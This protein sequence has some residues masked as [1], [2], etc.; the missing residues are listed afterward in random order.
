MSTNSLSLLLS[1]L[2]NWDSQ[3]SRAFVGEPVPLG[4]PLS[5][6]HYKN[7]IENHREAGME[8]LRSSLPLKESPEVTFPGMK[9]IIPVAHNYFLDHDN[10]NESLPSPS[11]NSEDSHRSSHLE[12]KTT[13]QPAKSNLSPE[14][15]PLNSLRT[16]HYS[17]G[18]DYHLWFREK[19]RTLEAEIQK[20]FPDEQFLSFT[21]SVPILERDFARQAGLGWRGKN[22]CLI[23]PKRGSFF[24][25]GEI[26]TSIEV[27]QP[28]SLMRNFCGTCNACVEAC[29][30]QALGDW[31]LDGNRCISYWNIEAKGV[32]P[33]K[34]RSSLGDWF[35][36]CDICQTVCPWNIKWHGKKEGFQANSENVT[37]EEI[38]NSENTQSLQG[39]VNELRWVLTSSNREL[40]K[41][42][43]ATALMRAGG[44]GLK[45]NA[46]I[47]AAN[48]KLTPL[49]PEIEAFRD[50]PRLGELAHWAINS[51]NS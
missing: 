19:L 33:E 39:L 49:L 43:G 1:I 2:K 20:Q 31:G 32:A 34:L 10:R 51:L 12:H 25:I 24:F 40:Q 28:Q 27:P 22:T 5:M 41:A 14:G 18:N 8:Y 42:L 44:R 15:F 48:K 50:H 16:A 47:V 38:E 3:Q 35:F 37:K 4:R 45:R 13:G 9:S 17:K 23:H 26:L 6:D 36:G 7:W 21:D 11:V 29:P 46:I 30:T